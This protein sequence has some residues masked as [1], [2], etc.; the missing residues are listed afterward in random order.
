MPSVHYKT[1]ADPT[2]DP[3]W[4]GITPEQDPRPLTE[5]EE[6]AIQALSATFTAALHR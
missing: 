2:Q 3:Y 5:A 1:T 6:V 4:R